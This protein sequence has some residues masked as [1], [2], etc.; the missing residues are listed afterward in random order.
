M[1]T[2]TL[3]WTCA[4]EDLTRVLELDA[5]IFTTTE[6]EGSKC[7][8]KR[9]DV[10]GLRPVHNCTDFMIIH[11]YPLLIYVGTLSVNHTSML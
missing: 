4:V 9:A 3:D 10:D 6:T 2:L 8:N 5:A 7:F 1:L 11:A